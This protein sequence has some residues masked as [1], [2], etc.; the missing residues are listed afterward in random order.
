MAEIFCQMMYSDALAEK[1]GDAYWRALLA[2]ALP[3]RTW[4]ADEFEPPNDALREACNRGER[5]VVA[6]DEEEWIVSVDWETGT[7]NVTGDVDPSAG[8]STQRIQR[9]MNALFETLRPRLGWCD[10][11]GPYPE[12]LAKDVLDVTVRWIFWLT[13]FGPAYVEKYGAAL[14]ERAPFVGV[15]MIDDIGVRCLVSDE[16]GGRDSQRV[17]ELTR[18]FAAA[19][20]TIR[21]YTR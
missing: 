13:Y 5:T 15:E 18:Y 14:F 16:L 7:L 21:G 4:A 11:D 20:I 2:L 6:F 10:R 8:D 17:R 3:V 19:S 1:K 12:G 9:A